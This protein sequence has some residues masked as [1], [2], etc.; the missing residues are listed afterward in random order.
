MSMFGWARNYKS[1][2][3]L[4]PPGGLDN[5]SCEDISLSFKNTLLHIFS[6]AHLIQILEITEAE[7]Q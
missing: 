6:Q 3:P 4:M 2:Y 5:D 1:V 7:Q